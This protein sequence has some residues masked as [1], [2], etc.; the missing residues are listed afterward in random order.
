[1]VL[2]SQ[3]PVQ[4]PGKT[5][6]PPRP[7][8]SCVSLNK[9]CAFSVTQFARLYSQDRNNISYGGNGVLIHIRCMEQCLERHALPVLLLGLRGWTRA[10]QLLA[11]FLAPPSLFVF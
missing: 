11:S 5:P 7:L 3:T 1:M 4:L 9:L 2:K 10:A 8:D 6:F